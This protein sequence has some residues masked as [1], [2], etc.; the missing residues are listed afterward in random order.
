[1]NRLA[2]V[3]CIV[4]V[5]GAASYGCAAGLPDEKTYTNTIGMRMVRLESGS[6]LMG[7]ATSKDRWDERPVHKVTITRPFHMSETE[8][9]V[10]Q[11]KQFDAD[12]SGDEEYSPY[13]SAVSWHE[14]VAFCRWLSGKEGKPY[15]LPTEAEW[16]YACRAGTTTPF[17][18]GDDVPDEGKSNLW[19]F[20]NMHTGVREWCLDWHGEYPPINQTDP[21][22]P[23]H[24][25]SKVVRGGGLDENGAEYARSASRAGIAPSF[26]PFARPGEKEETSEEDAGSSE[27]SVR[28]RPPASR[29]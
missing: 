29:G 16:E 19:G 15:R 10:E 7:D 5:A 21:V 6:F 2:K 1:M 3:I 18:S 12:Y 17:S 8:V 24:G 14:A 23:A 20:R 13:A 11:F 26:G 27:A 28:N 22:G 4:V 25:M 9:T